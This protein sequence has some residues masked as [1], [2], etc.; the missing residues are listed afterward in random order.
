ML[1]SEPEIAMRK[2][3]VGFDGSEEA[4]D[5]LALARLLAAGTGAE[6]IVAAAFGSMLAGPGVDLGVLQQSYFQNVF[7][8]AA[9]ALGSSGFERRE[10]R[11]AS[12]PRGL[13][14]LAEKEGADLIVIGS[15]HRGAVGRVLFGSVGERLL[16][17]GPCPV[18]I[19]PRGYVDAETLDK[20]VVGVAYDG[21]DEATR[22]LHAA[23]GLA[24]LLGGRL[25]VVTVVDDYS[26]SVVSPTMIPQEYLKAIEDSFQ[27]IQDEALEQIRGGIS[28]S[29]AVVHGPPAQIL[30]DSGAE[31]DLLVMGSRGYG[32][33][34]R[35]LLGGVSA[36]VMREA[37]C[38]V[39]VVPRG[40]AAD[41]SKAG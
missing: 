11:D 7:E 27:R 36:L 28:V 26:S 19:A 40:P 30:I 32:P 29:G 6:L 35:T 13:A 20:G 3:I 22:A 23:A 17:G 8:K 41:S 4:R 12:A 14:E 33:A 18:A 16:Y 25:S 21:S 34:R 10:L 2:I 5:G 39:I 9:N 24:T 15:A 37:P 38:P 1:D 31:M